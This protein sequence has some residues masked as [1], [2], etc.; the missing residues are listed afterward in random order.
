MD[1]PHLI[2]AVDDEPSFLLSIKKLLKISG[3]NVRTTDNPMLVMDEIRNY[4]FSA[5]LLD[6]QM[7]G[8]TG[9]ELIKQIL[10]ERPTI[11]IIVISG[12]SGIEVA[13]EAIKLGAF[14]FLQKPVDPERLIIVI[15]NAIKH[16]T[17]NYEKEML[18]REM[19][20][21][22]QIVGES[23]EIK[24]LRNEIAMIGI[25]N[26][27]VLILGESGTGKELVAWGIYHNSER[28]NKPYIKI[29][30]ASIPHDL[31]ESELFGYVKGAFTGANTDKIGKFK[32]ADGG[33]LFLDEIGELDISLQAK[34][35]RVLEENEIE[36]IGSNK[37]EKIDVRIIAAT[38][39]N[40]PDLIKEGRFREDLFHRLNV[41]RISVPPLRERREDIIPIAYYFLQKYN[42]EYNKKIL[43]ITPQAEGVL[44]NHNWIG[45]IRELRNV[46]ETMVVF[47]NNETIELNDIINAFNRSGYTIPNEL[48]KTESFTDLKTAKNNFEKHYILNALKANDWQI[49]KT[50]EILE[51]DRSNLFK[52]MKQ[53]GL[54][55]PEISEE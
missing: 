7:P 35:L 26:V 36:V 13:V 40:L 42:Q 38:N 10:A 55:K 4:N 3:F 30:C 21:S 50:A 39:K 5:V 11:P 44:R 16:V 19:E 51:I 1:N 15:N 34:L 23:T 31:I 2:L 32:A 45:N 53:Y 22:H 18:A 54:Q 28:K 37:T 6:I 41:A 43:R 48:K 24:Q 46:I 12:N 33:T 49:G 27:R 8:V 17:L 29:N 14:D 52:K 20:L 47:S 9:I 25:T